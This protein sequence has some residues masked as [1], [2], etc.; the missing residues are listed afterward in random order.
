[1]GW[2]QMPVERVCAMAKI[3]VIN[4]NLGVLDLLTTILRRKGHKV[5]LAELGRNGLKLF[6]QERP[7]VTILDLTMPDMDGFAVLR[8]IRALDRNAPVII[9]TGFG[10]EESVRQARELGVTEF[11]QK[12]SASY[13]LGAALDR[14][15]K[16]SGQ[17]A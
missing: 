14:V 17:A 2:D 11:L 3:L 1:M 7:H 9:Q 12:D 15:L 8:E 4:D 13:T 6:Q 5:V 10:T 16:Q